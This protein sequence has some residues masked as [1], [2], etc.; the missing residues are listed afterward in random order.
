MNSAAICL[1]TVKDIFYRYRQPFWQKDEKP[2]TAGL[3]DTGIPHT[4]NTAW[5][6][7]NT[8]IL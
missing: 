3:D 7:L 5:K 8:T 4:E 6:K 2:H 1:N